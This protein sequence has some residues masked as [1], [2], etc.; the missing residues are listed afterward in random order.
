MGIPS[1]CVWVIVEKVY[2][3][4]SIPQVGFEGFYSIQNLFLFI[5]VPRRDSVYFGKVCLKSDAP[6]NDTPKNADRGTL[7]IEI[8][9]TFSIK[10]GEEV[11][12]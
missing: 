5:K 10:T 7:D 12:F 8:L 3:V 2:P 4:G 9:N 1:P 11:R 6:A